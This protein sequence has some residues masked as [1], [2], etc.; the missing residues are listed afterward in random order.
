[1]PSLL[2]LSLAPPTLA[3]LQA[4]ALGKAQVVDTRLITSD[5]VRSCT[6][7]RPPPRPTN[8]GIERWWEGGKG[9][10]GN[11]GKEIKKLVWK[12]GPGRAPWGR[13]GRRRAEGSRRTA[14]SDTFTR[15]FPLLFRCCVAAWCLFLLHLL[16]F[17]LAFVSD[18]NLRWPTLLMLQFFFFLTVFWYLEVLCRDYKKCAEPFY[19]QENKVWY[20]GA[21]VECSRNISLLFIHC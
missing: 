7:A 4:D 2:P 12:S 17:I 14:Y 8:C 18:S 21:V 10:R 9:D 1:M 16:I 15:L 20:I 5:D 19:R 3:R 11:N 13:R 6:L